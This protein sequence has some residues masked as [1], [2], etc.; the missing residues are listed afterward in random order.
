MPG[1][2]RWRPWQLVVAVAAAA[3]ALTLALREGGVL[4]KTELTAFDHLASLRPA[5]RTTP[6]LALVAESEADLNRY[7]HPLSDEVLASLLERLLA[8]Q[9][10]AIVMDK[11]RDIPVA[12]GSERLA[13]LLERN[14]RIYWVR[15]MGD[16]RSA[17]VPS[18]GP[19]RGSPF[20]A[21]NDTVADA[22]GR[23]RRMLAYL[24]DGKGP[25]YSLAYSAARHA[26]QAAGT[27]VAFDAAGALTLGRAR[28]LPLDAG[29]GPYATAD[30]GG[31]QLPIAFAPIPKPIA[32]ADV[33]E[34]RVAPE[35]FRGKVV[36]FGSTAESLRDFFAVPAE[37]G[38]GGQL[39]GVEVHAAAS[40]SLM[41]VATGERA[42][43]AL[44]PRGWTWAL[45]GL[46]A[47]LAAAWALAIARTRHVA[48]L[49]LGTAGAIYGG[50]ALAMQRGLAVPLASPLFA[51]ALAGSMGLG[52][53]AW[54]E[55]SERSEMMS[56]FGR[57]V[58]PEVAEAIWAQRES[59]YEAGSI[60]SREVTATVLFLDIR[61]F[62][63]HT[64]VLG[65]RSIGWL[66]R[67]LAPLTDI[68]LGRKGVVTRFVG[69]QIMAVFGVPF[70]RTEPAQIAADALAAVETALDIRMKL[71][72]LGRELEGE[73]LPAIRVRIGINTGTMTQGSVGSRSRFEFSVFGDAVNAAARLES[74]ATEDDGTAARVLVSEATYR[75]CEGRFRCESLG[76]L[77]LKGKA[78]PV[79]VYRVLDRA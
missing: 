34:G 37:H 39:S 69:D 11:Y 75:L 53:R 59:L 3:T 62:T 71:E 18:P 16:E 17:G 31:F 50:T 4:E 57:L 38:V 7:G 48:A 51:V 32:L 68:V 40:V 9:P 45:G 21:C 5:A 67:G 10:T 1:R 65:T 19:L 12:P 15:K 49:L 28:L 23:V 6:A 61:S 72:E 46:A 44:A 54:R 60:A 66:N 20:E 47:L 30:I 8:A 70:P 74:Y 78:E 13:A 27:P 73:G 25:C 79:V 56:V 63:T 77:A 55:R 26:L 35:A 14:D 43:L 64:E 41:N 33:L 58:A 36:F 76:A 24:D 22:D 52:V 42:P 2:T 29:D